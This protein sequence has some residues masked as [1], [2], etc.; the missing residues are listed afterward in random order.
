MEP[1]ILER[2]EWIDT[3]V[4]LRTYAVLAAIGGWLLL[5]RGPAWLAAGGLAAPSLDDSALIR[6]CGSVAMAAACFAAG[7]AA[8]GDPAARRLAFGWFIAAHLVV[9][10]IL[11]LRRIAIWR[12]GLADQALWIVLTVT[13]GLIY[14]WTTSEGEGT[15]HHWSRMSLFETAPGT[16]A[17]LPRSANEQQIREAAGQEERKR[18]ARDLHDSVKQQI[19]AIQTS[20]ATAETRLAGDPAGARDAIGRVRESAREASAAMEALLDE[21]RAVPLNNA[22][23]VDAL[24]KQCHALGFRTGARVTF[25]VGTLPPDR[26]L[27]PGAYDAVFR[28]AQEALANVGRH[29][30]AASVSVSLEANGGR[31]ELTIRDDGPGLETGERRSGMGIANMR[32]RADE[33]GGA[34]TLTSR[35]GA[36]TTVQLCVPYATPELVQ[37]A[38]RRVLQRAAF[39]S[40][41]LGLSVA[42][43][44]KS[45]SVASGFVILAVIAVARYVVAYR[46][47]RAAGALAG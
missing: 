18:L 9:L 22:G 43:L 21:L 19:F 41:M 2:P 40:L 32:A 46:R 47:L 34:L 35:P 16:S 11:A 7:L 10:A 14:V 17:A 42:S 23:L 15:L 3:R 28:V 29:A 26:A 13:I 44:S 27:N 6:I 37:A 5:D 33:V 36:G 39:W 1:G 25:E 12:P 20:A 45:P 4:A 30:R 38:R 24:R 8:V 31:L